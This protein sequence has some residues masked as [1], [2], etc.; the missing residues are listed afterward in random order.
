MQ[1]LRH[2]EA[3]EELEQAALWYEK[4]QPGLGLEFLDE[5]EA[6]LRRIL[7]TPTRWRFYSGKNRKLN[8]DRFPY[9]IVYSI[10]ADSLLIR[11]VMDLRRR[12]GYWRW[13]R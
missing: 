3:D 11:A 10:E 7:A 4:A 6:T 1:L 13:R 8:F 9:A 5:F 2:P 12:P